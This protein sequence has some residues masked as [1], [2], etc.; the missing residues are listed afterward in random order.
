VA[1]LAQPALPWGLAV[2]PPVAGQT[3]HWTLE[4]S[5]PYCGGYR[6]GDGGYIRPEPP[7][8]LPQAVPDGSV[9]F[10]RQPASATLT[11]E[12]LRIAAER[13]VRSVGLTSRPERE[14]A[15]R[16]YRRVGFEQRET[17]VYVW[18]PR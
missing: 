5:A 12:A 13:G 15:N 11:R 9:L 16:L 18:R 17:N 7:M 2:D 6:I 3:P 8:A 4:L 10:Q 1:L 14:A